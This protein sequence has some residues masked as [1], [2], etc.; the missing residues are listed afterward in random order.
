MMALW[1][2]HSTHFLILFSPYSPFLEGKYYV[3]TD[4]PPQYFWKVLDEAVVAM[5]F[6]SLF[7]KFKIP[8]WLIMGLAHIALFAGNIYAFLTGT[9]KH[10]VNYHVKLNPFAAK[11]LMINRS[12]DISAAKRDLNYEPIIQFKDGWASTIQWFKKN[13]LPKYLE[14]K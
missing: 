13:W 10:I 2:Y 6:T 11:M 12:F 1:P 3:I 5:G 7:S 8:G 4:G 14:S 9:P